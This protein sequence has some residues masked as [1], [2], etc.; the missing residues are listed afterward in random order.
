MFT[1][2]NIR[3]IYLRLTARVVR[4]AGASAS[5]WDRASAIGCDGVTSFD[6]AA[7]GTQWS[8]SLLAS[9]HLVK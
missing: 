5:V 8:Q 6:G 3:R 4:P 7:R 1:L 9:D 2:I